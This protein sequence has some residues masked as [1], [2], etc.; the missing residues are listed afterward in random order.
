MAPTVGRVPI[1]GRARRAGR[2]R[3]GR[4]AD[5]PGVRHVPM[6]SAKSGDY[7]VAGGFHSVLDGVGVDF[8]A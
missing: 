8:L 2:R 4:R 3:I 6:W 7:S 5:E 1:S